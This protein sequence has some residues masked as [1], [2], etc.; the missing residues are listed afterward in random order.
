[1]RIVSQVRALLFINSTQISV[2]NPINALV[3]GV[4]GVVAT[5]KAAFAQ[6]MYLVNYA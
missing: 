3:E 1:M 2:T 4:K 5:V 6:P